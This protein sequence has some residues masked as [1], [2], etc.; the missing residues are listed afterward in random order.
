[1]VQPQAVGQDREYRNV[2]SHP[3]TQPFDRW[4]IDIIG[5]L[6]E[7]PNGNRWIITAIDYATGWP[8]AKA[9]KEATASA[10]ADFIHS[11]IFV[12]YGAPKEILSDNGRDLIAE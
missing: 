3:Y 10:V 2:L 8:L 4:G 7:T 5:I 6:S 9:I 11:E 1:M 12:N